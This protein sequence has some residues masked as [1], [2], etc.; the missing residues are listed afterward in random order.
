R[1]REVDHLEDDEA[2]DPVHGHDPKHM[3]SP[4][5]GEESLVRP[6]LRHGR[7]DRR[8]DG[9]SA[10]VASSFGFF[11]AVGTSFGVGESVAISPYLGY[12]QKGAEFDGESASY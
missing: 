2:D 11:A 5:L 4:E 7:Q 3:P 9:P 12:V 8:R 6:N 1:H 10:S